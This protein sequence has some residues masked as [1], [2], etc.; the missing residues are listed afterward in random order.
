MVQGALWILPNTGGLRDL[1]F[2][3]LTIALTTGKHTGEAEQLLSEG[4]ETIELLSKRGFI[5]RKNMIDYYRLIRNR[6]ILSAGLV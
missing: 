5:D 6:I 3:V 2:A 4:W 1:L